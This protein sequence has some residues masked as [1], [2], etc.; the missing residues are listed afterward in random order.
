MSH[1]Y[2]QS[3]LHDD[4]VN[5]EFNRVGGITLAVLGEENTEFFTLKETSSEASEGRP[6]YYFSKIGCKHC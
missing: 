5:T 6:S 4:I 1:N 2:I 3:N